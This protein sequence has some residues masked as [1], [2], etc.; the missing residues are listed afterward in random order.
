MNNLGYN[1]CPSLYIAATA[2]A[3][4]HFKLNLSLFY[5]LDNQPNYKFCM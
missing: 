5:Q 2:K 3:I 4:I 1:C